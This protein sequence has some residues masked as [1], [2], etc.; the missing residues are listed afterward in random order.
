MAKKSEEA[1][2]K[3]ERQIMD[4]LYKLGRATAAGI[5]DSLPNDPNYSTVRAQ[6]RVLEEKGHVSHREQDLRYVYTPT[7]P[8][9]KAKRSALKH[10]LDTFFEGSAGQAVAALLDDYSTKLTPEELDRV[11]KL[12]EQAKKEG[13]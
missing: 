1:L 3:R 6:L 10:V 12:I 5:R 13:V 7:V 9:D 11:S 8:R 4:I 2:S